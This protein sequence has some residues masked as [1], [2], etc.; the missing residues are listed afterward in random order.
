M[1]KYLLSL[2]DYISNFETMLIPL[3]IIS[4]LWLNALLHIGLKYIA[5]IPRTILR[6]SNKNP[7][8][9]GFQARRIYL[10][11]IRMQDTITEK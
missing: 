3:T 6:Y 2:Y 11:F 1:N 9:E 8:F 10:L 7:I 4:T 5:Y